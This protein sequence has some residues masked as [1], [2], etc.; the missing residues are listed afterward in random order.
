LAIVEKFLG[1][2]EAAPTFVLM[3][4]EEFQT[5]DLEETNLDH[6]IVHQWLGLAVSPD[7]DQGNWCE[8]LTLYFA[9][10]FL[11]EKPGKD[12]QSR[13]GVL[14][15]FQNNL[16]RGEEFPLRRFTERFDRSS[17]AIG[18]CKGAMVVHMLR[19]RLGS[20]V[21]LAGIKDFIKTNS[22]AIASWEDLKNSFER[23]AH[24]DLSRF[25]RQWVDHTGQ[26]D[27]N[28]SKIN[29]EKRG[30]KAAVSLTLTQGSQP[31]RLMVP[32][33]FSGPKGRQSFPVTLSRKTERFTFLLDFFPNEVVIDE[34]YDIL[35]KLRPAEN[36]PTLERLLTARNV[37][38]VP[39]LAGS[40]R[41]RK[42]IK[43]FTAK[44]ARVKHRL[45][46]NF[47]KGPDV[48]AKFNTHPG[49]PVHITNS[50]LI[51]P[52]WDR[53][54]L[55]PLLGKREPRGCSAALI[56]RNNQSSPE[57]MVAV[58]NAANEEE[59]SAL[60]KEAFANPSY[61]NYCSNDGKNFSTGITDSDRGIRLKI[62]RFQH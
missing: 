61:S 52:G 2:S 4:R 17:S 41:Y 29:L 39:P 6:E 53:P 46:S 21:F 59:V 42:V 56:V 51:F 16:R 22:S 45:A 9:D 47:A 3:G 18:Y 10:H 55:E 50:S 58:L 37:V 35:R 62:G 34:D 12:W 54:A 8:G 19:R 48:V 15:C 13:R 11:T 20:R 44:G 33:T 1:E 24:K 38:V 49:K 25:I 30:R 28:V 60:L 31:F 40:G 57:N 43:E 27:L 32:V 7:Y 23:V 5:P 26:A 36:P 14:A